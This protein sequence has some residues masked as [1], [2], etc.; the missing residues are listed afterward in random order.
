VTAGLSTAEQE[1]KDKWSMDEPDIAFNSSTNTFVLTF[2]NISD[3]L[4][5]AINMQESFYD[6]NCK[7]DGSGFGET[8]ISNLFFQPGYPDRRPYL[9]DINLNNNGA[10]LKFDVDYAEMA[11]EPKVYEVVGNSSLECSSSQLY[12]LDFEAYFNFTSPL[13]NF[14]NGD[15]ALWKVLNTNTGVEIV[16]GNLASTYNAAS[17][18][19]VKLVDPN[20]TQT[21]LYF[22]RGVD[23]TFNFEVPIGD[24]IPDLDPVIKGWYNS[25][26]TFDIIFDSSKLLKANS[27]DYSFNAPF[28]FPLNPSNPATDISGQDGKG[29]MKFCVRSSLGFYNTTNTPGQAYNWSK[30]LDEQIDLG[31]KEVNFIETLITI[32][33]DLT[34]G[35]NVTSFN[36]EPKERVETTFAEDQYGLEAWL[37]DDTAYDYSFTNDED[38][39][40]KV[41]P[42]SIALS[43]LANFTGDRKYFNQGALIEVCVAPD[44]DAWKDGI[45]MNGI[46]QFTWKRDDLEVPEKNALDNGQLIQ[47]NIEQS[48]IATGNQASNGLTSYLPSTCVG[49]FDYCKFASILFADFYISQGQVSGVGQANLQFG[50]KTRRLGDTE[51]R[52]LQNDPGA[53]SPF[54]VNVP[55]DLTDTGPG[56]LKTAGG[57]SFGIGTFT[58]TMALLGAVVLA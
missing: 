4:D 17:E 32:F 57:S 43:Y 44:N 34:A 31:F 22:C 29:M 8:E 21:P 49:G 2:K 51:G 15:K 3:S 20:S 7:D 1:L 30:T 37:C 41:V 11:K 28:N 53:A 42:K 48:A 33:F 14:N 12:S 40:N 13:G 36:V 19:G 38:I 54:D 25:R 27:T 45:R 35:F 10:E 23:Y 58:F 24:Y 18:K 56:S 9:Y 55:V 47:G 52:K 26:D 39:P 5:T 50:S 6:V 46:S 16:S